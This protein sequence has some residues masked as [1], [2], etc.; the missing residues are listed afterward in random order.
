MA[1]CKLAAP[2][3]NSSDCG[4]YGTVSYR[5]A[6]LRSRLRIRSASLSSS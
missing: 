5:A 1:I 4:W 3:V 6:S 2:Q